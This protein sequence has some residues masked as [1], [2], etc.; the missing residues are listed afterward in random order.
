MLKITVIAGITSFLAL[1][2]CVNRASYETA[3]VKVASPQG[4]VLCQLYSANIVL[5]D[6]A[7]SVPEGMLITTGD[8]ICH[9]EGLRIRAESLQ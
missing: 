3:P 6:Q 7:I 8:S 9:N 1:S 5:W 2:G 4:V